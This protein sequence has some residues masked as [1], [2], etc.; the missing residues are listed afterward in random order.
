MRRSLITLTT[1][2]GLTD[3]FV[4]VMK[5]VIAKIH[6]PAQVVDI[7]HE[8]T[9]FEI[10]EAAFL[11]SQT[12][13]Y[14]PGKTVHVIVVDPGVGTSRRPILAEAAG[15]YFLA[16]D[17]GVLSM[18][19]EQQ[20]HKVRTVTAERYFLHPLSNTF[21][22]RDIFAPVAAHLAKGTPPAKF[23]KLI[24]DYLRL[25]ISK[26]TRT[27]RRAW[28]GTILKA[29]RFGNLI[30]NFHIEEFPQVFERPFEL[31]IG[32]QKVS[33]LVK[34][35]AEAG[36]GEPVLVAGSSGYLEVAINQG[37]AAKILGCASGAPAELTIY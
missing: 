9:A 10:H 16:P 8:I 21:H 19:Y 29:D 14:F 7:A 26:P 28:T 15:Q 6:P 3:H 34:T 4:G 23:G 22:G 13:R 17:N 37:S 18:V 1:D 30:T 27:G 12:Y 35:Y 20:K 36:F 5:G 32:P 33:R 11:I 2:F 25:Q 31:A 24:T